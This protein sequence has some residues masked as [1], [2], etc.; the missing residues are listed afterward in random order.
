MKRGEIYCIDREFNEVGSEMRA[1]RPAI[2]VSNDTGNENAEIVEVVWLTTQPKKDLPTHVAI[3]STKYKS[4]ALCEQITT[5]AKKRIGEYCGTCTDNEM[6]AVEN[7]MMISL[8]IDY[9]DGD[10]YAE[11]ED[12]PSNSDELVRVTA[13]RDTYKKLYESLVT[14]LIGVVNEGGDKE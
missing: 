7:A 4:T 10:Y 9:G 8:G 6:I 12:A 5:V 2:I 3:R 14:K 11:E 13:E 1:G